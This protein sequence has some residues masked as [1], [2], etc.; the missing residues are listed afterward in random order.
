MRLILAFQRPILV[1]FFNLNLRLS[2]DCSSAALLSVKSDDC[3]VVLYGSNI[4]FPSKVLFLL[5]VIGRCSNCMILNFPA[6]LE[7]RMSK[8]FYI[9]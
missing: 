9:K 4:S 8:L 5:Y 6:A 1:L 7:K 2:C 3:T